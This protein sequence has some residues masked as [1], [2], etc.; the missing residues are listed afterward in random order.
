MNRECAGVKFKVDE[1]WYYRCLGDGSIIRIDIQDGDLCP[2]C[3]RPADFTFV[4]VD[5]R[6]VI[7]REI[8]F[9]TDVDWLPFQSMIL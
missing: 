3:N 5:T 2:A 7:H 4:E 8:R 6:T 9:K 1:K